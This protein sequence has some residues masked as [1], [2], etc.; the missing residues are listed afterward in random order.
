MLRNHSDIEQKAAWITILRFDRS[1]AAC[2]S[3]DKN[4]I[5]EKQGTKP[6]SAVAGKS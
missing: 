3:G 6:S 2:V 4:L 5:G 1:P